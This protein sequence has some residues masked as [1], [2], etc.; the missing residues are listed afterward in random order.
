MQA[1][2]GFLG[3][4][5]D[6][7]PRPE[8]VETSG[9]DHIHRFSGAGSPL[10]ERVLILNR[11][12]VPIRVVSARRAFVLLCKEAAEIIH[13]EVGGYRNYDL[14]SW[15]ELGAIQSVVEPERH[16]WVRSVRFSIAVPRI[17][18]LLDYDRMP[19]QVIKLSRRS[20]FA[21]DRHQCQYC[22]RVF[23]TDQLTIDHVV[24]RAQGGRD[25][26]DNLV[27]ACVRCNARKGGRTPTQASMSL[28]RAPHRP[29][30][31]PLIDLRL[32]H[33]KYACWRA[34][35]GDHTL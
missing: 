29:T 4:Q 35:L 23:S 24:P 19:K 12:Y 28:A 31:S 5:D 16:D 3:E 32:S 21:R 27:T 14:F 13:E 25:T 6:G 1:S 18:R 2:N 7:G 33:E 8:G 26:W 20:V 17:V 10:D 34:F 9:E 30:R 15:I 11:S 22:T